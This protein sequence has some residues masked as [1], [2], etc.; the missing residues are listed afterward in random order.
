MLFFFILDL[1][2]EIYTVNCG[3]TAIIKKNNKI[4]N[5]NLEEIYAQIQKQVTI[6]TENHEK[7]VLKGNKSAEARV[8]KAMG[9]VKKLVTPYRKA[10]VDATK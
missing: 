7:F 8:R 4:M 3:L 6:I 9:E 2:I 5:N 1:S 10:S